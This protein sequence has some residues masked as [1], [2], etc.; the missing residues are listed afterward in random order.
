LETP[1]TEEYAEM[2][3]DKGALG[4]AY[5]ADNAGLMKVRCS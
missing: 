3:A 4:K 5:K 1:F 2:A